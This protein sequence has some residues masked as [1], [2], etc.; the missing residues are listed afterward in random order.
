MIFRENNLANV[1]ESDFTSKIAKNET[2]KDYQVKL[3]PYKPINI[4]VR[5]QTTK[6][7]I[8]K[9]KKITAKP[10]GLMGSVY[11]LLPYGD[12]TSLVAEIKK[13]KRRPVTAKRGLR[14]QDNENVE[15]EKECTFSTKH[16]RLMKKRFSLLKEIE[17]GKKFSL[18]KPYIT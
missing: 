13:K 10:I 17:S 3:L 6:A 14:S 2:K 9:H 18:V 15:N 16:R 7:K 8:R 4:E 5:P 12:A 11:K 1:E